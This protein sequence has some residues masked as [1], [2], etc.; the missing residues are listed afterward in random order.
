MLILDLGFSPVV[1]REGVVR[2]I[3]IVIPGYGWM[4]KFVYEHDLGTREEW[5]RRYSRAHGVS[6]GAESMTLAAQDG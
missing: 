1:S 3:H 5:A 4:E 2:M 6:R